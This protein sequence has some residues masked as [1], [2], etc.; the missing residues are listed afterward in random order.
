MTRPHRYRPAQVLAILAA[1]VGLGVSIYLTI[2]HFTHGATL[3]CPES[4]TVNCLKVTTS[5]WSSIA[6]VPVAVLG[7]AYFAVMAILVLV[8]GLRRP[9]VPLR[10]V[11]AVAGVLT[12]LYLVYIELF[13]VDAICLWCTA[14]H[15]CVLVLFVTVLWD[16]LGG[17]PTATAR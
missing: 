13:R 17:R 1:V 8:P 10:V 9:V 16:A 6:G 15:L 14:V 4:A 12:A 11:G 7:L 2:E 3:A 5:R